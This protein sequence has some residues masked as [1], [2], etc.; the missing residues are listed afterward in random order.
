MTIS[1]SQE[2]DKNKKGRR[3]VILTEG[4]SV[5]QKMAPSDLGNIH[6]TRNDFLHLA[7]LLRT[8]PALHL[9]V[10]EK[11]PKPNS[12]WFFDIR[13]DEGYLFATT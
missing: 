6:T 1:L 13:K 12:I 4:S 3:C 10:D 7:G 8:L 2:R 5:V 9:C 11:M